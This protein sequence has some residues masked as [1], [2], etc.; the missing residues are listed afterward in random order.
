[1]C[2]VTGVIAPKSS[3]A[4]RQDMLHW[5]TLF[6]EKRGRDATGVAY[7]GGNGKMTVSKNGVRAEDYFNSELWADVKGH[8][9]A[10]SVGHCRA[11]TKVAGD[12]KDN[13]NNHPFYSEHSGIAMIHNGHMDD[14]KWRK[15]VGRP[16]GIMHDFTGLT[17]SEVM[18]RLVE[19]L[20][21]RED[22]SMDMD[23]AID[24]GCYN[25]AGSYT[26]AFLRESEPNK[27]WLVRHDNPLVLC[28]LPKHNAI[29]FASE[30]DIITSA[31]SQC[32]THLGFFRESFYPKHILQDAEE[33][34]LTSIQILEQEPFFEITTKKVECPKKTF[35]AGYNASWGT[36]D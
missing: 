27:I 14:D 8:L 24:N 18:L 13:V 6:S 11:A 35:Y 19:T 5:M 34:S 15:T 4:F 10:I 32:K 16:K 28:Y 22:N 20:V 25:I 29:L 26:L 36:G 30:E 7:V 1:M 9:P 31:I 23:K 12:P 17:D 3:L 33:D 21:L 2:G